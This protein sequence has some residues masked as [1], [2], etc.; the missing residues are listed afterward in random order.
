M[1]RLQRS[2]QDQAASG[3]CVCFPASPPYAHRVYVEHWYHSGAPQYS[4]ARSVELGITHASSNTQKL[5]NFSIPVR[6]YWLCTRFHT[7]LLI[8]SQIR[9][10]T[11]VP[12][13]CSS[14]SASI[15]PLNF[16]A[17]SRIGGRPED[18]CLPDQ[19]GLH[20]SAEFCSS[21]C[22]FY[23]I[24]RCSQRTSSLHR[25]G[26]SAPLMQAIR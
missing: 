18:T 21:T 10:Q 15:R 12:A 13:T 6:K 3:Y 16:D 11:D 8:R 19:G 17:P 14:F 26:L 4:A 1:S 25:C 20:E 9:A 24:V 2:N 23:T 22:R 7:T 5:E